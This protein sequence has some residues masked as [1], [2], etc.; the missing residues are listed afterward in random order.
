MKKTV[1]LGILFVSMTLSASAIYDPNN[2]HTDPNS[3][4][5]QLMKAT[6]ATPISASLNHSI[7]FEQGT[8][9]CGPQ[10]AD[11]ATITSLNVS[12]NETK[13]SIEGV[14]QTQHPKYNLSHAVEKVEEQ[15][16]ILR[17]NG[18]ETSKAAQRCFG[19]I[20][21]E[22]NFTANEGYLLEVHHNQ[23]KVAEKQMP[24]VVQEGSEPDIET[25]PIRPDSSNG[26]FASIM[27]SLKGLF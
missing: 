1:I 17:L 18:V 27:D 23:T 10:G 26:F 14:F 4:G 3:S 16:Y 19:N 20:G 25:Q 5:P 24:E 15:H 12:P 22:A 8:T 21:Y 9:T 6:G 7:N 11:N 2:T 13:V